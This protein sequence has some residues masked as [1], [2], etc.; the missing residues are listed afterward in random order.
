MNADTQYVHES[1]GQQKLFVTVA[2]EDIFKGYDFQ[3]EVTGVRFRE[4][5]VKSAMQRLREDNVALEQMTVTAQHSTQVIIGVTHSGSRTSI[6]ST[7]KR[8]YKLGPA[9]ASLTAAREPVEEFGAIRD[10]VLVNSMAGALD[11]QASDRLGLGIYAAWD[12]YTNNNTRIHLKSAVKYAPTVQSVASYNPTV[13]LSYEAYRNSRPTPGIDPYYNPGSYQKALVTFSAAK[14]IDGWALK[15]SGG[16]GGEVI[17]RVSGLAGGLE[18][19]LVAPRVRG[20]LASLSAGYE[21]DGARTG[22][23]SKLY[24]R[25]QVSLKLF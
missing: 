22:N 2:G 14:V 5:I 17:D 21:A 4:L 8:V 25:L 24:V 7:V 18:A 1:K 13:G 9:T 11:V 12:D 16:L 6:T 23:G 10:G 15:A 19:S 3:T 20:A